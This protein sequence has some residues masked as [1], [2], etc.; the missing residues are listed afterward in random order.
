MPVALPAAAAISAD[1]IFQL[2]EAH[3]AAFAA[4]MVALTLQNRLEQTDDRKAAWEV[5][6]KPGL[7]A[8]DAF[9]ALVT[10]PATTMPGLVAKLAYLQELW[11]DD[12]TGWLIDDCVHPTDLIN[13][14]AASVRI[15]GGLA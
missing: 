5:V 4:W 15:I 8:N 12:E 14:F 3:R 10:E 6:E 7:D 13:S 11:V 9:D 1:P 2:I